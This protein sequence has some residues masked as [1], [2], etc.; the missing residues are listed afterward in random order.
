MVIHM[1]HWQLITHDSSKMDT[2]SKFLKNLNKRELIHFQ[3]LNFTCC[4]RHF[5]ERRKKC[6]GGNFV[7]GTVWCLLPSAN[8]VWGKVIF[9]VILST[10]R[11]LYDV[12]SCL[13]AWSHVPSGV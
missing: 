6:Y 10:G 5:Q 4:R 9:S 11:S 1:L 3:V 13:A 8:E 12:T 7:D 2:L